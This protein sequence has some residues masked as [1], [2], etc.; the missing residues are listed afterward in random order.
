M[1]ELTTNIQRANSQVIFYWAWF[2]STDGIN[3]SVD[4]SRWEFLVTI[5][6]IQLHN[7]LIEANQ[8]SLSI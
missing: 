5:L 4:R 2:E 7:F 6:A 1:I 3:Y 8:I